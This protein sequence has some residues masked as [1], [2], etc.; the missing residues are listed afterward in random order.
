MTN[1]TYVFNVFLKIQKTWLFT[2]I[3]V[4]AH[5]FSNTVDQYG[6]EPFEQQQFGT[7]G[8]EGVNKRLTIVAQYNERNMKLLYNG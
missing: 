7:A 6:D 8:V 5:V 4:V 2:F 1:Y 3:W